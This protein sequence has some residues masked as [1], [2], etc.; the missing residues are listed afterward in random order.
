V[1][2]WVLR[3]GMV[4]S[5]ADLTCGPLGVLWAGDV[6]RHQSS[7]WAASDDIDTH[8][9]F[10]DLLARPQVAVECVTWDG[11]GDVVAVTHTDIDP[12]SLMPTR[13]VVAGDDPLAAPGSVVVA[14]AH[15]ALAALGVTW[16]AA[17][18]EIKLTAAGPD[19][20]E[21]S[22]RAAVLHLLARSRRRPRIRRRPPYPQPSS[23]APSPI[24][25]TAR[26]P[27]STRSSR[28]SSA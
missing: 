10:M 9:R 5:F 1:G 6:E 21:S 7:E 11:R 23:S 26:P 24:T 25:L 12:A 22:V 14:L 18:V 19:R 4:I 2:G 3:D 20:A 8:Y 27:V 16:G 15:R 28:S 13:H 17:H